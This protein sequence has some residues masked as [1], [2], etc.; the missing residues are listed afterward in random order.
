MHFEEVEIVE[1]G[2]AEELIKD[3]V[4]LEN[5]EGPVPSRIRTHLPVYAADAE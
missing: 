3:E 2:P 1:L 4:D 5:S